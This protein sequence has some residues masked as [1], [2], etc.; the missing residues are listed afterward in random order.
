MMD[1]VYT[2]TLD[3]TTLQAA[4]NALRSQVLYGPG[5]DVGL[6]LCS[7][8]WE[9]QVSRAGISGRPRAADLLAVY[10]DETGW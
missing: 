9:R 6:P 8:Q 10:G 2:G 1:K 7:W 5:A 4:V 3:A